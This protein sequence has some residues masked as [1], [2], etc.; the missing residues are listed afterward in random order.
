[1]R[2]LL[3]RHGESVGNIE[4]RI[5]GWNDDPLTD[6][7]RA[8]AEA[9]ARRLEATER[10]DAIYSSPL[11]RA[12]DTALAIAARQTL[13]VTCDERLRERGYGALAGLCLDQVDT[14]FPQYA[15]QRREGIWSA[16]VPGQEEHE[17]F[18]ARV[19]ACT[20]EILGRHAD[21]ETIAIVAHMGPLVAYLVRL[22]GLDC[23]KPSPFLFDNASLSI[24][25]IEP[26]RSRL[27][28]F[29]DTCHLKG[30]EAEDEQRAAEEA[31]HKYLRNF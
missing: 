12:R 26:F 8:Q 25:L 29:N 15:Q 10:I 7:G 24:V 6:R 20:D 19:G 28:L 17:V 1:M 21:H 2:L 18:N 9:I 31:N 13:E 30:I 14:R 22:M 27:V 5:Q 23:R 11:S 4:R 3:I 16:T